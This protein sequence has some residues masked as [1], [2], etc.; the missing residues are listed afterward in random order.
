MP[1]GWVFPRWQDLGDENTWN[2]G[3]E[4]QEQEHP[5]SEIS[6]PAELRLYCVGKVRSKRSEFNAGGGRTGLG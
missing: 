1:V 4:L 2:C 3:L 6:N 5:S